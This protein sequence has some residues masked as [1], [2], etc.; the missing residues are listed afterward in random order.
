MLFSS[1]PVVGSG[2][3][4]L[5]NDPDGVSG[6]LVSALAG[7]GY[8]FAPDGE[9]DAGEAGILGLGNLILDAK[10]IINVQNIE[11]VGVSLGAV[12]QSDTSGGIGNLTGLSSLDTT[13]SVTEEASMMKNTQER[14]K[15]MVKAL[16][17]SLVPR[18]LA[19]EVTGFSEEESANCEGLV[20]KQLQQCLEGQ[21]H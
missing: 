15:E 13:S 1:P 9:I 10:Q 19:V 12:T 11:S 5:T 2:I 18:W 17:E 21:A 4:L 6:P 8:I 14:F 7:N 20:G 3:Q 16:G